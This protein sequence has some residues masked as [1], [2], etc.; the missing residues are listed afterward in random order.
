M[1]FFGFFKSKSSTELEQEKAVEV[2]KLSQSY[3][4]KITAA[5]EK[6]GSVAPPPGTS[7][8][9]QSAAGR[10]KKTR[11]SKKSRNGRKSSRL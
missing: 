11:R 3:D 9:G 5:K 6:E 2:Q 8:L 1:S 10:R 4:E 7:S